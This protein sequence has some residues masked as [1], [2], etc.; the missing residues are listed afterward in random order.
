VTPT[1]AILAAEADRYRAMVEG[2]VGALRSMCDP[3]L[4]YVMSSGEIDTL[5]SW[6]EKISERR[7]RYD[8]IEHPVER[9]DIRG[10]V[11]VVSG[12]MLMSGAL[13]GT[14]LTAS[15]L[16]TG[17]LTRDGSSWRLLVFHATREV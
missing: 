16:T 14:L 1:Q 9:V 6:L 2:D 3:A 17:I 13:D 5:E 11:A 8:R 15:N 7:Y 12:R 4:R 10:D